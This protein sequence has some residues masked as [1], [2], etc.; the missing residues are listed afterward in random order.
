MEK[1]TIEQLSDILSESIIL[2][3]Q[4][5]AGMRINELQH[6]TRGDLITIQS[7]GGGLLFGN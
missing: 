1:L 5:H 7:D 3:T 6:P 2:S 4:D